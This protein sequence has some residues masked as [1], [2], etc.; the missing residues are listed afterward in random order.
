MSDYGERMM[1]SAYA[2]GLANKQVI[3]LARRHCL[4]MAFVADGGHGM[5]EAATGLPV[6]SR[7]IECP[8]A[9]GNAQAMNLEWVAVEFYRGHCVGCQYRRQTGELPSLATLVEEQDAGRT[10]FDVE[11]LAAVERNRVIWQDRQDR[12]QALLVGADL[13]M[14]GALEDI[15]ILDIEPGSE[16]D[17]AVRAAAIQRL[18]ALADRAPGVFTD[19][20]V[21]LAIGLVEHQRVTELLDPLRRLARTRTELG[22]AVLSSALR[23]LRDGPDFRAASCVT[24]LA[25]HLASEEIDNEIV[26]S[27]VTIA[28]APD[29]PFPFRGRQP[30]DP[31]ALRTIA[32]I[33]PDLIAELLADLLPFPTQ[34][35][36]LVMPPGID[37]PHQSGHVDDFIRASAAGSASVLAITH[38]QIVL[39]LI[40]PLVRSLGVD[41]DDYHEDSP[42]HATQRALATMLVLHVGD[43]TAALE[44]TGRHASKVMRGRLFG[45]FD[46]AA[47]LADPNDRWREPGDPELDDDQQRD[48]ISELLA[49]CFR[50]VGGDWGL[51]IAYEAAQAAEHLAT[52]DPQWALQHVA[53]FIGSFLMVVDQANTPP[54][55]SLD[56]PA[57]Q[58]PLLET[59]E[60]MNRETNFSSIA[61]ELLDAV[62]SAAAADPKRVCADIIDVVE[63][64]RDNIRGP[65]VRQRLVRALGDIGRDYGSEPGLLA[66]LLPAVYSYLVDTD[67]GLR[68]A[69]IRAWTEIGVTHEMPSSLA[70]LLPALTTDNFVVVVSAVLEAAAKLTWADDDRLSLCEYAANI[71][72]QVPAS[73]DNDLLAQS[74]SALFALLDDDLAKRLAGERLIVSRLADLDNYRLRDMLLHHWLAVVQSSSAM[75]QLRLRLA[76]DPVINDRFNGRDDRQMCD[77]LDCGLGLSSLPLTDLIAAAVELGPAGPLAAA[78]FAEVAWRANRP[79][80]A[81]EIMRAIGAIVL[82]TP[83]Y[84]LQRDLTQILADAADLDASLAL[85]TSAENAASTLANAV[86]AFDGGDHIRV[87]NLLEQIQLRLTIRTLLSHSSS[88]PPLAKSPTFEVD[89][90][91]ALRRRAE[92]LGDAGK[93]LMNLSQRATATGLY[94]RCAASLCDIAAFLLRFDAAELDGDASAVEANRTAAHRRTNLVEIEL[95]E[96]F[97]PED[98]LAGPILEACSRLQS[99]TTGTDVQGA[100]ASLAKLPMPLTL[101]DGPR[102]AARNTG[103]S[104]SQDSTPSE[105]EVAV[106]LVSV[107]DQLV[108]GPEVLRPNWVYELMLEVQPTTW[109]DWADRL[110]A[111]L[112]GHVTPSEITLPTFSWSRADLSSDGRLIGRGSMVLRF[113]LAAGRPA[114]PFVVRLQWRGNQDGVAVSEPIDIAGHRQLRFRPF[115]ASRDGLTDYPMVDERLLALYDNLHGAGYNEDHIQAFCRLFTATCRVGFRVT[116]DKKYK[117]GSRVPERDF[118][119]DLFE[120]LSAEAELGGRLE[121]GSPLALGYLDVRHDGIT[122]ELKVER[123]V[124]VTRSH[125]PKYMGQP[126]Q[127]AAADGARLSILC[128]LDMSPKESPVGTPENYMFTLDPALHGLENPEAPSLVAV[129]VVNGNLPPPSSFSRRKTRLR[130]R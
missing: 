2:M 73:T 3:E 86:T 82:G 20:V 61:R 48:L 107:D 118:H 57:I 60:R 97:F 30:N 49:V 80:D 59:L 16:L 111:E 7:R 110:D 28:G 104:A 126:T 37:V 9:R 40:D 90:A 91:D 101:L 13:A 35:S 25:I 76:R 102:R 71:C 11:R 100:L 10:N 88:S 62:K 56:A 84:K 39:D 87:R 92:L 67:A 63:D 22:P 45:V 120:R 14:Q 68:A 1:E 18:D 95:R 94:M 38:P 74:M 108:T 46:R 122:A 44:A 66:Q 43:V 79:A 117:R 36:G 41:S 15:A 64:E 125:A 27:L 93:H 69:S 52:A 17:T 119:D 51:D 81:A 4:H 24:E 31:S 89:P 12:R 127:Y 128:V 32:D 23:I 5:A 47:Q 55:P 21:D 106:V 116:W 83:A 8:Q 114:P 124:P 98:P 58:P 19:A 115:D 50:R 34:N 123:A 121:R 112:L 77:L 129:V 29:D 103:G 33:A 65:I 99:I 75:A 26:S 105:P 42:I 72:S 113:G 53:S 70:D 78:E 130:T 85:G 96:H 6:D 109:P 54:A